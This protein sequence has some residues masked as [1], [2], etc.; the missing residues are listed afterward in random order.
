MLAAVDVGKSML[1][2]A[3]HTPCPCNILHQTLYPTYHWRHPA[4]LYCVHRQNLLSSYV[5]DPVSDPAFFGGC[6]RPGEFKKLLFGLCFFHASVQV[7][8]LERV[9]AGRAG[10]ALDAR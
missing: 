9:L 4:S 5:S 2:G 3:M 10:C 8:L 6:Q 7:S 1:T